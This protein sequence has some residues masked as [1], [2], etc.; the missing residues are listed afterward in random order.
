MFGMKKTQQP[1]RAEYTCAVIPAAGT[2]SRMGGENKLMLALGDIPV[3][4]RTLSVF[5]ACAEI[6]EIIIACRPADIIP[7]GKLIQDFGLTKVTNIVCGG[8]NRT[9]S[10]LAGLRACPAHTTLVAIHD[11]ARPLVTED[12]IA[13]TLVVAKEHGAAAPVTPLKDSIKHIAQEK[14]LSDVPRDSIAAVQT[15]QIFRYDLILQALT[16][17]TQSNLQ[18]TDDCAAVEAL[19][20]CV[21]ATH[22]SY[23]NI[24]ITTP[25]DIAIAEAILYR[26]DVQQ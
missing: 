18:Y 11:G 4:I 17:A 14:I 9:Q 6:D 26:R 7:Y 15:P 3:L 10:V 16:Q 21:H 20:V 1:T 5:S 25:E 13:H 24:K 19:G 8:E 12:I 2:A 23:E 22:G